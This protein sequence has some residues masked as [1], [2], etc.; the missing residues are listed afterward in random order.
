MAIEAKQVST[1]EQ[2]IL[3]K[4]FLSMKNSQLSGRQGGGAN[5]DAYEYTMLVESKGTN[6]VSIILITIRM[7]NALKFSQGE[8]S[9][10]WPPSIL[11]P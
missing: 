1:C 8:C 3:G 2:E 7:M 4:L 10:Q 5:L 11:V 6:H 9:P